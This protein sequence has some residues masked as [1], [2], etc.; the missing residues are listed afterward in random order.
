MTTEKERKEDIQET[1]QDLEEDVALLQL[2]LLG[3]QPAID[4]LTL[5]CLLRLTDYLKQRVRDLVVLCK[6]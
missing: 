4:Q 5:R 6:E 2:A 3:T 1:L